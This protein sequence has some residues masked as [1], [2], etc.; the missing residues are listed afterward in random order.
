MM[1][2]MMVAAPARTFISSSPSAT[3]SHITPAT[4]RIPHPN[5]QL[6]PV[7]VHKAPEADVFIA[8]RCY[9]TPL[10]RSAATSWILSSIARSAPGKHPADLFVLVEVSFSSNYWKTG[11]QALAMSMAGIHRPGA[12]P[13]TALMPEGISQHNH[14]LAV[15]LREERVGKVGRAQPLPRVAPN[16]YDMPRWFD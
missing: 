11:P 7:E 1:M 6:V 10:S 13:P 5:N 14:L 12:P 3:S 16:P 2:T 4:S 8:M 9:P 15:A